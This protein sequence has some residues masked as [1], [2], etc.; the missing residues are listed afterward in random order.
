MGPGYALSGLMAA[1]RERVAVELS[2]RTRAGQGGAAWSVADQ[3]AY[4]AGLIADMLRLHAEQSIAAGRRTLTAA[5]EEQVARGVLDGLFALGGL[6]PLLDDP[7]IENINVNG[8][9]VVWVRYADGQRRRMPP[10]AA[11]DEDLIE[12]VRTV[13]AR[14][15][16]EERRFDRA[17]PRLNMQLPDGSRLFAAMAVTARPVVSIRRHR[18]PRVSLDH[19]VEMGTLSAELR[20]VLRGLVLARRNILVAG[21]TGVGKTTLIRALAADVPADERII[22]I[23]DSLELGLDRDGLHQDVVA[24]QAREANVEGEGEI[25]LAELVRWALRMSPDRVIVGEVRGGEVVPML[26]AMSQGTDGSLATIHASSSAGV[27][28]KIAAYAAQADGL[29]MEATTL[30]TAAAVHVVVHMTVTQGRRVV[31]SV[32]E[33]TGADGLLVTSNE[34]WRPGADGAAVPAVPL[35]AE[36]A[37]AVDAALAG[38]YTAPAA[39]TGAW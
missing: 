39:G 16:V 12:L 37:A 25:G 2:A 24:M 8:C 20:T 6:Q 34:V 36:T 30:L 11:S 7:Q 13:A 27:F 38:Y 17:S 22:T 33:V 26:M 14:A 28:A 19:L 5:E 29:A 21:E 15:G 1:L 9:D 32:R 3:R 23:E 31:S 35:R 18:Y 4:A 10:V